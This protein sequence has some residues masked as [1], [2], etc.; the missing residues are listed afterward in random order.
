MHTQTDTQ[1]LGVV[2][3]FCNPD[4][5]WEDD[6]W[7]S[8]ENPRKL[9]DWPAWHMAEEIN[10]NEA[11]SSLFPKDKGGR[12]LYPMSILQ[13][14]YAFTHTPQY[15]CVPMITYTVTQCTQTKNFYAYSH[16]SSCFSLKFRAFIAR[17]SLILC[18]SSRPRM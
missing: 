2:L 12:A 18:H 11:S 17:A 10:R 16:P 15:I 5:P 3:C 1:K 8:Q 4:T 9:T 6:R 14:S 7:Q 13:V